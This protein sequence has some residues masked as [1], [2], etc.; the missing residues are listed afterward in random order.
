MK[1]NNALLVAGLMAAPLSAMASM[2]AMDD[3]E[4]SKV[5]GE[6]YVYS[7]GTRPIVAVR[8]LDE[9][10][11]QIGSW[12]V[13]ADI[14]TYESTH[15]KVAAAAH[16]FVAGVGNVVLGIAPTF[17]PGTSALYLLKAPSITYVPMP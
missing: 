10:N 7:I 2:S 15:P 3:N 6:G 5:A 14:R 1:V 9:R 11:V 4:L 13:S 8:G 17:I 16:A 12:Q